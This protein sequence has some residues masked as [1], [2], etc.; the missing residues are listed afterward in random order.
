MKTAEGVSVSQIV[1]VM[2]VKIAS[3]GA[4]IEMMSPRAQTLE[5]PG[6]AVTPAYL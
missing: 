5:A 3:Y 6:H 1:P 4:V 2:A